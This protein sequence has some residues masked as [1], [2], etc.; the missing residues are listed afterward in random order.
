MKFALKM[1]ENV[2][3]LFEK[4]GKLAFLYPVYEAAE[5]FMFTPD[6]VTE[7]RPHV[8]EAVDSKRFMITVAVALMPCILFGMWNIGHQ[9]NL[10]TA[11]AETG[12]ITDILKGM[13][14]MLPLILVSYAVGGFWEVLFAAVKKHEINEGFLVTGLLFPLTLPPTVPLWQVAVGI[15]FGVVIGKEIFGGVGYNILNPALTARAYLFFAHPAQMSGDGVW[16]R[17]AASATAVD[18]FTGATPLAVTNNL[19]ADGNAVEALRAAGFDWLDMFLGLIPGSVAETSTLC[20]LIGL[21][22]LLVT[23]VAERRI[24]F[25]GIAGLF[26]GAT[27]LNLLSDGSGYAALPFHYHLVMGGFMFGITFMATDP[28]SAAASGPGKYI[29]GFL[30]GFLVVIVRVFNP[31]F[32]EATM[33]VILFM[34]VMAP[35]IDHYVVQAHIKRRMR[36]A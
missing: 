32:P 19:A 15:S 16:T 21:A 26:A 1:L 17:I 33:L 4:G 28:V 31:A 24:I 11:G 14:A 18:G 13:I 5:T 8:R 25:S 30:I 29:Y 10:A 6:K 22:I 3:P 9:Q 12:F 36:H 20:C 23:G 7:G 27:L 34:N 35:M 2:K